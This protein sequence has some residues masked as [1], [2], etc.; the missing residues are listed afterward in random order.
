MLDDRV[1]PLWVVVSIEQERIVVHAKPRVLV[2]EVPEG[3]AVDDVGV[4]AE[5][6]EDIVVLVFLE[7][8]LEVCNLSLA[9]VETQSAAHILVD[10]DVKLGHVD[11]I[12]ELLVLDDG[13]VNVLRLRAI[14]IVVALHSDTVDRHAGILHLLDHIVDAD[15]LCRVGLIVVVV[16]EEGIRV[17]LTRILESLCDELVA[18][19]LEERRVTV[20]RSA[21]PALLVGHSL[22]DHV[23]AIND[24]L[25]AGNDGIDVALHI[26]EE[27]L[28]GEKLSIFVLIHP[29]ADLAMPYEAVAAEFDA[30]CAAEVSD[31]VSLLPVVNAL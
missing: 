24:V 11:V 19:N 16:E 6:L 25:V 15:A 8:L 2:A 18:G 10:A 3:N 22:I 7:H 1:S 20:R 4:L 21:R 29:A 5:Y 13:S 12:D 31:L 27:F 17:S 23:P 28:L 30:V 26:G 14:D 9:L